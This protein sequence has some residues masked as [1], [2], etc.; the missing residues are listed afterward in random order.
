MLLIFVSSC[1]STVTK[2]ESSP[3]GAKVFLKGEY[4]GITP[5][6]VSLYN[7]GDKYYYV[8][9]EK[10]QYNLVNFNDYSRF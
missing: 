9:L 3:A 10:D 7:R 6:E 5:T 8:R 4:I 1:I 2:I